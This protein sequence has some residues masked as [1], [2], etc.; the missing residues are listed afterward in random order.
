MISKKIAIFGN[1]N[2]EMRAKNIRNYAMYKPNSG[3]S[4]LF[5]SH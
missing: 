4:K 5:G 3:M 1:K 2:R